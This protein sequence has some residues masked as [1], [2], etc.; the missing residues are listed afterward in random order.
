[1]Y[2]SLVARCDIGRE[3]CAES[4]PPAELG[5][6]LRTPIVNERKIQEVIAVMQDENY[7]LHFRIETHANLE[8]IFIGHSKSDMIYHMNV[9]LFKAGPKSDFKTYKKILG[10]DGKL[11]E[12]YHKKLKP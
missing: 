1:M 6:H 9:E 8:R 7:K 4:R 3:R 12:N 2:G 11:Y 10:P 5:P